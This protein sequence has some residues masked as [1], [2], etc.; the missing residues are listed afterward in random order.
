MNMS[1]FLVLLLEVRCIP[2][3]VP[4]YLQSLIK[5]SWL[6]SSSFLIFAEIKTD[7]KLNSS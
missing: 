7:A 4:I 5:L 1:G 3:A 2:N 6:N